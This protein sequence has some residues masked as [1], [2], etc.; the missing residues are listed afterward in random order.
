VTSSDLESRLRGALAAR[1]PRTGELPPGRPAAVLLMLFERDGDP[2]LVFTRRT[3]HVAHH[4]GEISFPGG[5]RDD[6]DADIEATA[7]RET[8]EELGID[9]GDIT[10]VG[11]LD[12]WP[13]FVTGYNVAPFV[14][15]VPEQHAYRPSDAEID[16]VIELP[17]DELARVGRRDTIM[18]R[19]FPIDTNIFETRGHFI[20]GFT[21]AVLRQFLDEIWPAVRDDATETKD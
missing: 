5:G 15:V 8:V 13:T 20:W 2:W 4:K 21:G 12:D 9:P 18:R 3:H 16:E 7:V 11:R 6:E 1:P 14:A 19:G 10:I 17:V